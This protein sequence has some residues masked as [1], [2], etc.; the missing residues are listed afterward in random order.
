MKK[1]L[2]SLL[3]FA[4]SFVNAQ[5]QVLNYVP[6]FVLSLSQFP[7]S[8][9]IIDGYIK[10]PT[11]RPVALVSA[12]FQLYSTSNTNG[13]LNNSL[14]YIFMGQTTLGTSK[15]SSIM[16][17][18]TV[19]SKTIDQTGLYLPV[20]INTPWYGYLPVVRDGL[21]NT[22]VLYDIYYNGRI[23]ASTGISGLSLM[24]GF[25]YLDTPGVPFYTPN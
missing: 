17:T 21:T 2:F 10:I 25:K 1:L 3:V 24:L 20:S 23:A 11:T 22:A 19:T 8:T 9:Q 7:A 18:I 14:C 13:L 5:Q 12:S 6:D 16:K 15:V 4:C